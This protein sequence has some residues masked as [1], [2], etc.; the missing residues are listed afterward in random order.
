MNDAFEP[1]SV[2]RVVSKQ[3][4]KIFEKSKGLF[5]RYALSLIIEVATEAMK[6]M[7]AR[8]RQNAALYI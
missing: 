5:R 1:A 3:L 2:G 8:T 4:M 6:K 7:W